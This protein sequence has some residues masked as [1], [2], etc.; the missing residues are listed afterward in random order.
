MLSA[1]IKA[2]G[3]IVNEWCVPERQYTLYSDTTILAKEYESIN[4]V[5]KIKKK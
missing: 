3:K 5:R 2:S 4:S 1:I